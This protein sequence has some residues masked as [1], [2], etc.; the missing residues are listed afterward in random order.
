MTDDKTKEKEDSSLKEKTY[1]LTESQ[2]AGII[3][4]YEQS[5]FPAKDVIPAIRALRS[6]TVHYDPQV[7]NS[8]PVID[9]AYDLMEKKG[10][11]ETE[12]ATK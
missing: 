6:L 3:S 8:N 7:V 2:L 10:L 1:L 5:H 12:G 4:T 9:K 11:L